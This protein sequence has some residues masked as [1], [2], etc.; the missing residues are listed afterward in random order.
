MLQLAMS[1]PPL[2]ASYARTEEGEK[3][4]EDKE[5]AKEA[6][7]EAKKAKEAKDEAKAKEAKECRR[8]CECDG[9]NEFCARCSNDVGG[10]PMASTGAPQPEA[11]ETQEGE[12]AK[13]GKEAKGGGEAQE[14]QE[15]EE[16]KEG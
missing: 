8:V 4:H 6:K 11:E 2:H 5:E 10:V 7:E 14:G 15:A 16:T 1:M 9:R 3:A 12:E 13:D